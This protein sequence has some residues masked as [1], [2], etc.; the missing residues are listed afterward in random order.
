MIAA[1]LFSA[2]IAGV[3]GAIIYTDHMTATNTVAVYILN[4]DV[5]GGALMTDGDVSQQNVRADDQQFQTAEVRPID[6]LIKQTRYGL[7]MKQH[8]ILRQDD[9]I[10]AAKNVEVPINV[11]GDSIPG[12]VAGDRV[13]IYA[14][15]AQQAVVVGPKVQVVSGGAPLVIAVPAADEPFW[16]ALTFAKTEL[17]ATRAGA[18]ALPPAACA[19]S[20]Q[21]AAVCRGAIPRVPGQ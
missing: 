10:A 14:Y 18:T 6:Q 4:K 15:S 8:D 20:Q 11:R 7:S 19:L 16:V 21:A 2:V 1:V 17:L 5:V 13:D 9:L 3:L 12:I